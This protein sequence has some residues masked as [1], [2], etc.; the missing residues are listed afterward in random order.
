RMVSLV[1]RSLAAIAYEVEPMAEDAYV[2]LYSDLLANEPTGAVSSDPRDAAVLDHPLQAEASSARGQQAVLMHRTRR[3]GL[4]VAAGMD[5]V[6]EVPPGARTKI[7]RAH[8]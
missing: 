1:H 6:L 2:A 7:G 4:R 3:S 8:V 5:H